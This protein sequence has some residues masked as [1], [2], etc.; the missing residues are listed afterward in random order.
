VF[1]VICAALRSNVSLLGGGFLAS[2]GV[3]RLLVLM[4]VSFIRLFTGRVYVGLQVASVGLGVLPVFVCLA[5][6]G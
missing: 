5:P 6:L 4:A 2:C 1:D 3:F